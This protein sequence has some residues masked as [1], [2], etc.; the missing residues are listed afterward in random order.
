M[1][2]SNKK[3]SGTPVPL[4]AE[5]WLMG[6]ENEFDV[7]QVIKEKKLRL[8]LRLVSRRLTC[9]QIRAKHQ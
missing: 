9:P 8:T 5:M 4:E 3:L 7:T 6:I 1:R 2:E